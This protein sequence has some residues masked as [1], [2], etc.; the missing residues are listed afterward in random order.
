MTIHTPIQQR[1]LQRTIFPTLSPLMSSISGFDLDISLT[2]QTC[3]FELSWGRKQRLVAELTYPNTL[4]NF[5]QNWQ[6]AYL[7]FYQSALRA[8]SQWSG[9][10]TLPPPDWRAELVQAEAR[11]LAEFHYWLNSAELVEIRKEIVRAATDPGERKAVGQKDA[12]EP[13]DVFLTCNSIELE[14]L[15]WETWQIGTEFAATRTIRIARA[16]ANIRAEPGQRQQ[17]GKIRILAILGDDTGLNFQADRDAIQMIS[18]RAEVVFV[19]WQQGH[20][21]AN[22]KERICQAIADDRGW[23]ILFFAGHSNETEITGGELAIAPGESILLQEI[24]PKLL[25]AKERGLQFA[26]FNSCNG[27]SIA[28]MLIDLGLSQVA[29]MREPIHN[30]VAQEFLLRFVQSLTEYHDA[31]DALLSA[32]QFLKLEKNLTYPSAYL[33]PSLFRHPDS[34]PFQL[35]PSGWKHRLKQWMPTRREAIALSAL[36][37]LGWLPPMQDWLLEQRVWMQ[38]IYRQPIGLPGSS[39]PPPIL[40]VQ[41]DDASIQK[42]RISRVEPMDRGYIARVVDQLVALDAR[43]IGIDFLLDRHTDENNRLQNSLESA[44]RQR[45][46]WF[47]FASRQKDGKWVS[48]LPEIARPTWSLQG[49]MWVPFWHIRPLPWLASTPPPFS[50]QLAVAHRLEAIDLPQTPF[51]S[52]LPRPS[53]QSAVSL[54]EQVEVYIQQD[55]IQQ[56]EKN[57]FETASMRL[58]PITAFSYLLNQRWLQPILDFS[59]PPTQVYQTVPAWQIVADGNAWLQSRNL[60]SLRGMVVILAPGG[61]DEAGIVASE[62]NFPIPAAMAHWRKKLAPTATQAPF[63]G[64]EAHAY[65][66]HHFLTKHLVIPIPALWLLPIAALLGKG[67]TILFMQQGRRWFVIAV[68]LTVGY[69]LMSLVVY[70]FAAI[71]L[72]WLLPVVTGWV[73]VLLYITRKYN[74]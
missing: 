66:V 15:P 13:V 38:A 73:Y 43:V 30:R 70:Q 16:P 32:C 22:L 60:P 56:D 29:I 17:P 74:A 72:P 48:V 51:A 57:S 31:H 1:P 59:I 67:A 6:S 9:V 46:T 24:A 71:L 25:I 64:G 69:G 49:D 21:A 14:R 40:V 36:F 39:A 37:F 63:T 53:L 34:V 54:Q 55:E 23:D 3:K 65:M 58:Q 26:I 19:G 12:D 68:G 61:Y 47:V 42:D 27:L 35:K 18:P 45:E 4:T 52:P 11:L 41:I 28:Q 5:Y 50:Y 8:K 62:D 20:S 33:V 10:V 44:I 2:G 7:S